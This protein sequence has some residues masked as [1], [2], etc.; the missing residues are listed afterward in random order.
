M[1]IIVFIIAFAI[2]G[3]SFWGGMG[4]ERKLTKEPD[5]I[6]SAYLKYYGFFQIKGTPAWAHPV[7]ADWGQVT[8]ILQPAVIEKTNENTWLLTVTNDLKTGVSVDCLNT[9]KDLKRWVEFIDQ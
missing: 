5:P 8:M 1:W 7:K 6:D 2:L 9:E 4:C 3:L